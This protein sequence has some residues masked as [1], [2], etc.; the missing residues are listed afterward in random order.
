MARLDQPAGTLRDLA[1]GQGKREDTGYTSE[2]HRTGFEESE[3]EGLTLNVRSEGVMG[4]MDCAH[5]V[6]SAM[7]EL[8]FL[9]SKHKSVL[10]GLWPSALTM[11]VSR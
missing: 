7:S 2:S 11:E 6:Q 4:V 3:Y 10:L 5:A 8:S 1:P 9:S